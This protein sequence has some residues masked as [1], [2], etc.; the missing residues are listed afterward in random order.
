[1]RLDNYFSPERRRE[2]RVSIMFPAILSWREGGEEIRQQA[3]TFSIS[4]SGAGIIVKK[5][6]PAGK[7]ILVTLDVGGLKGSAQAEVRWA[8]E[9][10]D[11][12]QIGVCF[13]CD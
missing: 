2:K 10:D 11:R 6:I 12:C 9:S 5:L 8:A 13:V 3:T 7:K 1:M 4:N